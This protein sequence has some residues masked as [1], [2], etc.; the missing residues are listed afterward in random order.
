MFKFKVIKDG[1]NLDLK[2][3]DKQKAKPVKASDEIYEVAIDKAKKHNLLER[4]SAYPEYIEILP[5]EKKNKE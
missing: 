2:N 5:Q 3:F 1:I 4:F